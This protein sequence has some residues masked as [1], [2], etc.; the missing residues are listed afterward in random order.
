MTIGAPKG[1]TKFEKA[2]NLSVADLARGRVLYRS[3]NY[4]DSQIPSETD[5]PLVPNLGSFDPPSK[6]SIVIP[7]IFISHVR[8]S[9]YLPNR[10]AHL[11]QP[12]ANIMMYAKPGTH[13]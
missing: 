1:T 12:N 2:E 6:F 9:G 3:H 7:K 11:R 5:L 4:P 13:A 8:M 10:R